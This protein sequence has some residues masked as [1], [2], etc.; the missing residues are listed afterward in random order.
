MQALEV[1]GFLAK[2]A[3]IFSGQGCSIVAS[4]FITTKRRA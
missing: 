4:E 2:V 3:L 1:A